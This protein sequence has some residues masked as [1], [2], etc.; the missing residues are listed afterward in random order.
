M[1]LDAT[2]LIAYFAVF[3]RC[4][5][6]L[7][8]SPLYGAIVPVIVRILSSAVIS[9]A[10]VPVVQHQIGPVPDSIGAL[11]ML[12]GREALYGLLIGMCLQFFL[13]AVQAAGS[14]MDLQ[15]GIGSA[16]LFNPNMNG[17]STTIGQFKFWLGL[18]LLFLANGHHMMF[19]AF[20]GSYSSTLSLSGDVLESGLRLVGVLL[21]LSAQIAAPVVAVTVLIDLAAGFVNKAVPQSQPFLLSLPAKLALGIVA[22]SLGLP[23]MVTTIHWGMDR[24]FE[25]MAHMLGG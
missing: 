2:F 9:L 7:L 8:S 25:G 13:G 18:V 1:R 19:T 21:A 22:L 5:A 14:L 23:A 20:V 17:S 6:M 4:S 10:L 24:T 16:Q 11:V 12:A 15:L 3:V